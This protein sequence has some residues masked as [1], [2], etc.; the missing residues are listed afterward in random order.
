MVSISETCCWLSL[1]SVFSLSA[2]PWIRCLHLVRSFWKPFDYTDWSF[3][4]CEWIW[5]VQSPQGG[6]CLRY[7]FIAWTLA[8]GTIWDDLRYLEHSDG[9]G[10]YNMGLMED[11]CLDGFRLADSSQLDYY[12]VSPKAMASTFRCLQNYTPEIKDIKSSLLTHT[13]TSTWCG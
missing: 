5:T 8:P 13:R 3:A 2:L 11:L 6:R 7:R 4:D 1:E 10:R 9:S 12:T